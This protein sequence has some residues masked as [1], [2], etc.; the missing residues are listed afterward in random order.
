[1]CLFVCVFDR[2]DERTT[3][4]LQEDKKAVN[5]KKNKMDEEEKT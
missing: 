1:M 2:A 3:L 5:D 4:H